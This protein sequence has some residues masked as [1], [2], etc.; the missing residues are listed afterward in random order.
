MEKKKSEGLHMEF[1]NYDKFESFR[2]FGGIRIED[3]FVMRAEGF[4][5]LGAPL[6]RTVKEIEEA[7]YQAFA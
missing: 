5:K 2:D 4:E 3:N 1:I 7:R 6:A